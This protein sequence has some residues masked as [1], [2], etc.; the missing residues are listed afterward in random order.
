ME[1]IK[2][3]IGCLAIV[4][5]LIFVYLREVGV[6][7][8]KRTYSL[9][10]AIYICA[11]VWIIFDGATSYTVNHLETV[12][13]TLNLIFHM[14]FYVSIE[15]MV[16]LMFLYILSITEGIPSK[17]WQKVLISLPFAV[18]IVLCFFLI[19][20]IVFIQGS[21]SNYS[22]SGSASTC[23]LIVILYF[24]LTFITFFHRWKFIEK[25]KRMTIFVYMAVSIVVLVAQYNFPEILITS[26][27]PVIFVL[28]IYLNHEE[29]AVKKLQAYNHDTV[30]DFA[31]LVENRDNNT[32]GHIKRTTAYVSLLVNALRARGYHSDLLTKDFI[33]NLKM[34]AP[35][36][37]IGKISTPDAILQKPG[38]LT[39][40]EYAIMKQ[41]ATKGSEII[42]ETFGKRDNSDFIDMAYDVAR[43]H[44][45]K[46]NG[47]GYPTG[48]KDTEIPL[49]A[50]IMAVADVFDA[51]SQKR[52]YREAMPLD[53]CFEII[54]KGR[55]S[56]FDPVLVDI[57][58][59]E[60]EK[61]EEVYKQ[62]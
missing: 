56:D 39:D 55:G 28:G 21:I 53:E 42:K 6:D 54:K 1:Y 5:F 7:P 44:H 51:V 48:L 18:S 3:Q 12:N 32:G 13:Y 31:T 15:T 33:N 62:I 30:V 27:V 36:H 37:D 20:N 23:Y 50:R 60:R 2:L 38:K 22:S 11:I 17:I 59:E 49:A 58:L 26:I 4:F 14:C 10:S 9:F 25:R 46:W 35:M 41:H 29:P 40:E 45:E 52:C 8:K 34:A 61:V 57:F 43:F 16:F 24:I 19:D 47:R